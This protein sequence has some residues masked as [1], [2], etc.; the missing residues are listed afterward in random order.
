[1][2]SRALGFLSVSI[3]AV[4]VVLGVP[5]IVEQITLLPPIADHIGTF[6]SPF[7]LPAVANTALFVASVAAST[8]R[9]L[10]LRYSW[11]LDGSAFGGGTFGGN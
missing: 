2:L 3:L 9:A 6:S 1:M 4:A 10:R 11:L 8:E 5:Q 7:R